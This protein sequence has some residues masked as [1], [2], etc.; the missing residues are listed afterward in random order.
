VDTEY[1][2]I[3]HLAREFNKI[4]PTTGLPTDEV[5]NIFF[6][7]VE[8]SKSLVLLILDEMDQLLKRTGDEVIYNLTRI[9]SELKNSQISLIGIS[10][11]LNFANE[12]DPRVKSSLS[13]EKVFFSAYD[14]LQIQDILKERSKFAFK[15]DVI[16][17]GVIEK[18]AAYAARDHGDARR[19]LELLRVAGEIAERR[20]KDKISIED[21]D[22]ADEKIEESKVVDAVTK[23]PKQFQA[24]LYSI[25]TLDEKKTKKDDLFTGDVYEIY[26]KLCK[27]ISLRPLTQRRVS[28]IIAELNMLGIIG[29]VVVSNGRY[30]R[31][32]KIN[33]AIQE[34]LMPKV[35][36]ILISDLGV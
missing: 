35:K 34:Q 9:N 25:I 24:V 10:N 16:E 27:K 2:L 19:A 20:E 31:T 28:E 1:R 15:K 33:I 14:A 30:G 4:I 6:D 3:A 22:E 32:R 8:N 18:C 12:L 5:Y 7:A 23:Q 36:D 11:D 13:E 29:T 21:L 17:S 26:K